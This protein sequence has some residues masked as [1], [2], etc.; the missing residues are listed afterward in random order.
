MK[1]AII[2]VAVLMVAALLASGCTRT[3]KTLVTPGGEEV[4]VRTEKSVQ[5][6]KGTIEVETKEGKSTITTEAK[7]TITEAE[8]GV[9][10]YPGSTVKASSEYE[11]GKGSFAQHMLVTTDSFEDVQKF[12]KSRLK[13]VQTSYSAT[14]EG[15]KMVTFVLGGDKGA[16]TVSIT[17][18]EEEKETIIAVTKTAE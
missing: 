4:T 16:T 9:P 3:K 2:I 13:N 17:A 5:G 10:V 11:G 18:D 15:Q 7:K 6:D 8:L 12:Y 1:K 14:H